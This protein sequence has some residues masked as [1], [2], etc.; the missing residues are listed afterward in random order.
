MQLQIERA[1][2]KVWGLYTWVG[3]RL[4]QLWMV[5]VG[6]LWDGGL[7]CYYSLAGTVPD[8]PRPWRLQWPQQDSAA[9]EK[10]VRA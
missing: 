5:W 3:V 6:V 10:E 9:P 2:E 7:H 4:E 1:G 8:S